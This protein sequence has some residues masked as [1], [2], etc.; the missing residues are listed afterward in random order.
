MVS[1][2]EHSALLQFHL[3]ARGHLWPEVWRWDVNA[4]PSRWRGVRLDSEGRVVGLEVKFSQ[5]ERWGFAGVFLSR[6]RNAG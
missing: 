6:H 3:A 2:R 1:E 4:D 5:T